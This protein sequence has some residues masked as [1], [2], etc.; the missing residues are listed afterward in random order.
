MVF[1]FSIPLTCHLHLYHFRE[2]NIELNDLFAER[3]HEMMMVSMVAMLTIT[4]MSM[5]GHL[6]THKSIA[7]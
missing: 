6:P 3:T 2:A 7:K 4:A 5:V 1:K